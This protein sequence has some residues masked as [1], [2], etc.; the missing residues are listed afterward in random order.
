[1]QIYQKQGLTSS[2]SKDGQDV[3]FACSLSIFS[4]QTPTPFPRCQA[5]PG[6]PAFRHILLLRHHQ[7]SSPPPST[8][9][10]P[11]LLLTQTLAN[12]DLLHENENFATGRSPSRPNPGEGKK[13]A[14]KNSLTV[15]VAAVTMVSGMASVARRRQEVHLAGW[16]TDFVTAR[17]LASKTN[18]CPRRRLG[19][20][21]GRQNG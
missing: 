10:P 4:R 15:A 3:Y 6:K 12:L 13:P 19:L 2:I 18:G 1:M 16:R 7:F 9:I 11:P 8:R 21:C 17:Q 5:A 14:K 20:G